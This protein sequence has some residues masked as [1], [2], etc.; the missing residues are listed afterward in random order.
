MRGYPL[1]PAR[2]VSEE[3]RRGLYLFFFGTHDHQWVPV[4]RCHMYEEKESAIPDL[5]RT[6]KYDKFKT[7]LEEVQKY[8]GNIRSLFG[9]VCFPGGEGGEER[10]G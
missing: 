7:A 1:W 3:K 5:A 10:E 2:V 4:S 9:Q 6:S 8:V